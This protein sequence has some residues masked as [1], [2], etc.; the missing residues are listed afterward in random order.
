MRATTMCRYTEMVPNGTP[1]GEA[2]GTS[3]AGRVDVRRPLHINC[4]T[5]GINLLS[6]VLQNISCAVTFDREFSGLFR[7]R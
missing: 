6:K 4:K 1:N 5:G 3:I 2:Y 7:I